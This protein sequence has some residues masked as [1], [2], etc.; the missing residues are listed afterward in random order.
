MFTPKW[1]K[2]ALHLVK[3]ARKFVHYKRDLLE[4]NRV[5]EIE[6]RRTDLLT[7]LD[8]DDRIKPFLHVKGGFLRPQKRLGYRIQPVP[9]HLKDPFINLN[10]PLQDILQTAV[11][12][13][14]VP[15]DGAFVLPQ[16]CHPRAGHQ[17]LFVKRVHVFNFLQQ[18]F[19]LPLI[20]LAACIKPIGLFTQLRLALS[21]DFYLP[22][23]HLCIGMKDALLRLKKFRQ[24]GVLLKQGRKLGGHFQLCQPVQFGLQPNFLAQRAHNRNR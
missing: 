5:A 20:G 16:A 23:Q 21:E 9:T 8:I 19:Q 3:G 14:K 17:T 15:H 6:S 11:E 22:P 2:E 1:K 18:Q 7:R 13:A 12:R 4:A 24:T 10:S